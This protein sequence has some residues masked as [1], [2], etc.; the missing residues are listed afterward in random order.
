MQQSHELFPSFYF[1]ST[2]AKVQPKVLLSA[3]SPPGNHYNQESP[4]LLA[5]GM[6][7]RQRPNRARSRPLQGLLGEI[8]RSKMADFDA[9]LDAKQRT[10]TIDCTRIN[11]Y[12]IRLSKMDS[13]LIDRS[14]S[15]HQR[16]TQLR[17]SL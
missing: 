2:P 5:S 16:I 17:D 7:G 8:G 14:E 6:A 1:R 12:L 3:K 9:R 10:P 13:E 11:H 15:I 4:V